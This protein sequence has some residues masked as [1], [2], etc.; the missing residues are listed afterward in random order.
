MVINFCGFGKLDAYEW[1]QG[2]T[3]EEEAW[4]SKERYLVE[5]LMV[6]IC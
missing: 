1:K 5:I 4:S 6:K 2:M 3:D